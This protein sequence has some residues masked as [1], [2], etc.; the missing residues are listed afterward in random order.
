MVD[1]IILFK[2]LAS[3]YEQLLEHW[4]DKSIKETREAI[5]TLLDFEIC[6]NRNSGKNGK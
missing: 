4:T 6:I 1:N 2:A 3:E 5:V